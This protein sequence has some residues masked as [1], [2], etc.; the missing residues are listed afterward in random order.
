MKERFD[1]KQNILRQ[2]HARAHTHTL[3]PRVELRAGP[4]TQSF[5]MECVKKAPGEQK[6]EDNCLESST[7]YQTSSTFLPTC[8]Q[9]FLLVLSFS[10][11]DSRSLSALEG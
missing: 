4:P 1:N 2:E 8:Q 11:P 3:L 5:K 7:A 6:S 10:V 9:I